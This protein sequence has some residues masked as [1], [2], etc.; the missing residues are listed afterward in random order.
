[1]V[2]NRWSH[3]H[4]HG[5]GLFIKHEL[6]K[7]SHPSLSCPGSYADLLRAPL[8]EVLP[9]A[10]LES[11]GIPD[12]VSVNNPPR[13]CPVTKISSHSVAL[14]QRWIT[15]TVRLSVQTPAARFLSRSCVYAHTY[16]AW[17][18]P[19]LWSH[20]FRTHNNSRFDSRQILLK[21]N[22]YIYS[23]EN[24]STQFFFDK[25]STFVMLHPNKTLGSFLN[26][27]IIQICVCTQAQMHVL[28]H[29]VYMRASASDQ[30]WFSLHTCIYIHTHIR[31]HAYMSMRIQVYIRL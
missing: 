6:Q 2:A 28:M 26:S 4:S 24:I 30:L 7:S 25:F 1:M 10:P 21:I 23:L 8:H 15:S 20:I 22:S 11:G 16:Q 27:I 17:W 14:L 29:S 12:M 31:I 13:A 18:K 5:H 9:K 3:G 19:C